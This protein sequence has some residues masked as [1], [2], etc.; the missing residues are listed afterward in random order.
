LSARQPYRAVNIIPN[1]DDGGNGNGVIQEQGI[2]GGR[3][4][5]VQGDDLTNLQYR[6]RLGGSGACTARQSQQALNQALV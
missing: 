3:S 5:S 1:W 4:K 2:Q 6:R